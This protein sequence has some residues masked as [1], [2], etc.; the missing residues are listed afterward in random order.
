MRLCN[1]RR[2]CTCFCCLSILIEK[3][4]NNFAKKAMWF[5]FGLNIPVCVFMT[6]TV[7]VFLFNLVKWL[8]IGNVSRPKC[9]WSITC[10]RCRCCSNFDQKLLFGA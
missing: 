5:L 1:F 4:E 9:T 6:F 2:V 10:R 3:L 8:S 7:N